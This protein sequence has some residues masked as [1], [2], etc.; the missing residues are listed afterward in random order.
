MLDLWSRALG[1]AAETHGVEMN[2]EAAAIASAHGHSVT[3]ARIEDAD[4][5]R[6]H[7]DLV[8]SLHVVEHVADPTSFMGAIRA[9]LRPGGYCLIDT[10]NIDTFDFRLFGGHHWG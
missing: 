9:A 6:A 5:P 4:L 2:R 8:Y 7:F 10:P 1:G 3:A